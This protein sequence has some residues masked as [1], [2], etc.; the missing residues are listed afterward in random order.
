MF[1]SLC[2][3]IPPRGTAWLPLDGFQWNL[4]FQSFLKIRRENSVL[5]KIWQDLHLRRKYIYDDILHTSEND[6][7]DKHCREN[8]KH[9]FCIQ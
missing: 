9:T 2:L 4:K 3:P 6:V 8:Q 5:I 7:S 1:A